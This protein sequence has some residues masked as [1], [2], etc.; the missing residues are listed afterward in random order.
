[1]KFL[2][3]LYLLA[4]FGATDVF[5]VR[6]LSHSSRHMLKSGQW[7]KHP[8]AKKWYENEDFLKMLKEVNS[9]QHLGQEARN[10]VLSNHG[11]DKLAELNLMLTV[12]RV[13]ELG[14]RERLAAALGILAYERLLSRAKQ[15]E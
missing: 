8:V 1:M 9:D 13:S 3:V 11:E 7:F 12:Q 10:L 14:E 2:G 4:V 5:A 6:A 15:P